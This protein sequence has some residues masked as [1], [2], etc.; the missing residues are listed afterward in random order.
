MGGDE[1]IAG[2]D[3]FKKHYLMSASYI[4]ATQKIMHA[5]YTKR[6]R[7]LVE[8]QMSKQMISTHYGSAMIEVAQGAARA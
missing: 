5:A 8:K 7:G 1:V 3:K 4:E 2:E 6:G